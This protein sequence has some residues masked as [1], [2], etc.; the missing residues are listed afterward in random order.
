MMKKL[1]YAGIEVRMHT[2]VK[3]VHSPLL[4]LNLEPK[5]V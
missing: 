4:V 1:Q 2:T 3:S 5:S